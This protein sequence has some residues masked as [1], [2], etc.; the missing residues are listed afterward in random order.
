[1]TDVAVFSRRRPSLPSVFLGPG[2][3]PEAHAVGEKVYAEAIVH[4]G[5][6]YRRPDLV[7]S[8]TVAP[9]KPAPAVRQH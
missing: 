6:I 1:M 5:H 9:G 3:E 4:A 8:W 2:D 7:S